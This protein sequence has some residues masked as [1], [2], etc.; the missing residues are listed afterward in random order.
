MNAMTQ[1]RLEL[2][3]IRYHHA[4]AG[5]LRQDHGEYS[6]SWVR[7]RTEGPEERATIAATISFCAQR[8]SP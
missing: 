7:E 4:I 5:H 8:K 6:S 2:E 1:R 3:N